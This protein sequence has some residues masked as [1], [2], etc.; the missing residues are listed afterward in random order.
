VTPSA[1][2]FDGVSLIVATLGEHDLSPLLDS[3]EK[4]S[5]DKYECIVIDQSDEKKVAFVVTRYRNIKYVHST[6]KGN[7][8]NR[9]I[10]IAHAKMPIVGFPD[11]DCF[12]SPDVV[13]KVLEAFH[14]R[15]DLAGIS[16]SWM[17]SLAGNLVMGGSKNKY[18]N[19]FNSWTTITNLTIFLRT[20][21]VKNVHGYDEY[22]GL[23]SGFFEG[24]EE[25]DF[26]IKI[27]QDGGTVLFDPDIKI[28][29]RQDD[30]LVS[31]LKKQLG[32]EESWGALFRKWSSSGKNRITIFLT[33]L[34]M[35]FRS[36]MA[37]LLWALRGNFNHARSYLMKNKARVAGWKKYG[38][39]QR[40]GKKN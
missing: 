30:Y 18:A 16:G 3:L 32:Y 24:G 39:S 38:S 10:G 1:H 5:C 6:R 19:H 25:T 4:Q 7:S 2:E 26:I 28:W 33:F 21:V 9:N 13:E 36:F 31:N 11:D 15:P 8:F 40:M 29:H 22:F 12:Y 27:I 34:Y 35:L 23:G 37:A 20:D 14:L 17:N